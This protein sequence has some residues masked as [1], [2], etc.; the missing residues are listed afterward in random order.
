M[1][2]SKADIVGSYKLWAGA[3][4]IQFGW[5][6]PRAYMMF[7]C[8]MRPLYISWLYGALQRINLRGAAQYLQT[9]STLLVFT[10]VLVSQSTQRKGE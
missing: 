5:A 7:I 2:F 6:A 4:S 9:A 3:E 1:Q 8:L 10:A